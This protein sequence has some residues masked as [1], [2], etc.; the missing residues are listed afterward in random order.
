MANELTLH[1]SDW[2]ELHKGF[3]LTLNS[4][5]TAIIGPNG[6][7]KTTL[8]NQL[9]EYAEKNDFVLWSYSNVVEGSFATQMYLDSGKFEDL[10]TAAFASEGEKVAFNFSRTIQEIGMTVRKAHLARKPCLILLDA[11]DSG[12]SIDRARDLRNLFEI[13]HKDM[14]GSP[15]YAVMAVNQYEIAQAPTDCVNARNGEHITFPTYGEYA[16]FI[17]AFE[18]KFPR[19]RTKPSCKKSNR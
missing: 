14:Q 10:A 18:K 4:G 5:F 7:G 9:K 12:A 16:D 13:I 1:I 6:A 8:L 3:D 19:I 17:C 11:V 2:H 15:A